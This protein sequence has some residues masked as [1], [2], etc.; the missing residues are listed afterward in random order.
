ME[1]AWRRG[2]VEGNRLTRDDSARMYLVSR[3]KPL[4]RA[5]EPSQRQSRRRWMLDTL[6]TRTAGLASR[7]RRRTSDM[8]VPWGTSTTEAVLGWTACPAAATRNV[9]VFLRNAGGMFGLSRKVCSRQRTDFFAQRVGSYRASCGQAKGKDIFCA[10]G[11]R[12]FFMK[13]Q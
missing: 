13:P 3:L 6:I 8:G 10:M 11:K 4:L 1:G 7:T 9:T 12:Q 2:G 5:R